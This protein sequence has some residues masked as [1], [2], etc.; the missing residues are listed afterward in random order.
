MDRHG[1]RKGAGRSDTP[2]R[3]AL[4]FALVDLMAQ[5]PFADIGVRELCLAAHVSRSTFYA[6]YDNTVCLLREIE[7]AHV[8]AIDAL[9]A[10]VADP[11]VS[12]LAAMGFYDATLAYIRANERDF[13]ALLV[14]DPQPRFSARWKDAIKGHLRARSAAANLPERSELAME[15]AAS[16]VVAA[17]AYLL[18]HPAAASDGGV[19]AILARVLDA[20]DA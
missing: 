19:R 8:A 20:L 13:R 5:K 15:L 17:C 11:S 16:S 10:P 6:Y 14:A 9:N 4:R 18:E 1:Q 7:D 12:G 2:A 3:E